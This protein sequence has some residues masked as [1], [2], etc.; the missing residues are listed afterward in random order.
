MREETYV[1]ALNS[2]SWFTVAFLL[3]YL[4]IWVAVNYSSGPGKRAEVAAE[5]G[6]TAAAPVPV[7]TVCAAENS[8]SA[9]N[10]PQSPA[11]EPGQEDSE[12][13]Q[14]RRSQRAGKPRAKKGGKKH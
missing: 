9:S 4:C 3:A 5:P 1:R 6:A 10:G 7:D 11:A 8:D 12:D 14:P 13:A 2:F